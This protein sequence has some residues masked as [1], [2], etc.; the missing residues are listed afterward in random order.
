MRYLIKA[1]SLVSLVFLLLTSNISAHQPQLF[2]NTDNT[3]SLMIDSTPHEVVVSLQC[4][5]DITSSGK[6]LVFVNTDV[7]TST[8]ITFNDVNVL[9]VNVKGLQV[10]GGYKLKGFGSVQSLIDSYRDSTILVQEDNLFL[11]IYMLSV[12][13]KERPL[14]LDVNGVEYYFD[15]INYDV[16]VLLEQCRYE[17]KALAIK[18]SYLK[19]MTKLKETR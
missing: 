17:S 5:P 14:I 1:V 16:R 7:F 4:V 15:V 11:F 8:E 6:L 9:E 3:N 18:D 2:L 13:S 10:D 12:S 19:K